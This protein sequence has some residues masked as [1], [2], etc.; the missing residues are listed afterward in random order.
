MKSKQN[1]KEW[2]LRELAELVDAGFIPKYATIRD[3]WP[4]YVMFV[5]LTIMVIIAA[6]VVFVSGM[7]GSDLGLAIVALT[8]LVISLTGLSDMDPEPSLDRTAKLQRCIQLN[9][10]RMKGVQD[11]PEDRHPL[12]GAVIRLKLQNPSASVVPIL[13]Y[14][15]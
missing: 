5:L 2:S 4:R 8:A 13:N 7:T 9:M 10:E 14:K 6:D 11:V 1:V 3:Y 15:W 12:L